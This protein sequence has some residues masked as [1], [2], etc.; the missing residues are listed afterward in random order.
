[1]KNRGWLLNVKHWS[2]LKEVKKYTHICIFESRGHELSR[3]FTSIWKWKSKCRNRWVSVKTVKIWKNID[4][5]VGESYINGK[6]NEKW[7]DWCTIYIIP[8]QPVGTRS[9]EAAHLFWVGKYPLFDM[10]RAL[11]SH[12]PSLS[13]KTAVRRQSNLGLPIIKLR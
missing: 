10:G 4:W 7:T 11:T 1:M 9:D 8:R 13:G 5:Q 6:I 2:P 12:G 3:N